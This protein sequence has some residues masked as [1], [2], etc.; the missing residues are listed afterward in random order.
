MSKLSFYKVW[1]LVTE[2]AP[3]PPPGGPPGGDLGGMGA[4]PG[5]MGGPPGGDP[6][7]G[8]PSGGGAQQP[9]PVEEIPVAN[10]WKILEKIA[11]DEKYGKFFEEISINKPKKSEVFTKQE[12]KKEKKKS[13]LM[14]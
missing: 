14:R 9:I 7:G 13:S 8:D 1:N 6:M 5:G 2:A 3:P 4:P 11:K 12:Q 10:A